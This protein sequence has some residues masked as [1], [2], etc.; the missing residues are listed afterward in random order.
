[1]PGSA[2]KS[3]TG[4]NPSTPAKGSRRPSNT[5][6]RNS[7]GKS[8]AGG[9]KLSVSSA[10]SA[11]DSVDNGSVPKLRKAKGDELED[12]GAE[13][14]PD[15]LKPLFLSAPT[16]GI[17]TCVTDKDVTVEE[18]FKLISKQSIID[19][20]MK[21]AAVSDFSVMKQTIQ[22]YP[23]ENLLIA[24]DPYF[25]FGENFY[26]ALTEEAKERILKLILHLQHES[27]ITLRSNEC[28]GDRSILP[29]LDPEEEKMEE[30][31]RK[32]AESVG[33]RPG[34]PKEKKVLASAST[35]YFVGTEDGEIVYLDWTLEKDTETGKLVHKSPEWVKVTHDGPVKTLERSP[36]FKNVLLS[37]G[38]WNFSIWIEGTPEPLIQ[39]QSHN[40]QLTNGRWSPSRPAVFFISKSDGTI[41]VW[42][43]L[44][45]TS[46]PVLTQSVSPHSI[47]KLNPIKISSNQ[48]LLAIGDSY[49]TLH[50]LE[51]PWVFRQSSAKE[52]QLVMG[53]LMREKD[54]LEYME[55][56][57]EGRVGEKRERDAKIAHQKQLDAAAAKITE[58]DE[59]AQAEKEMQDYL[60]LEHKL[61]IE[62]GLKEEIL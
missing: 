5:K 15:D 32:Q 48:Q 19:D 7:S 33:L 16:Q 47:T 21:R 61:Q 4:S 20:M 56:R 17:F 26:L 40:S 3:P 12:T 6:T 50:V 42:D 14:P 52:P 54:R 2:V 55:M 25:K 31:K 36:F 38:G 35:H 45:K 57:R 49:G 30:E 37:V 44:D 1:M 22:A 8:R 39:S 58:E 46:D 11:T 23:G 29:S 28:P 10:K 53:Y 18:P 41:D 62:L 24:Y 43:L 59:L 27:T 13:T 60:S 9:T 51:V 34:S